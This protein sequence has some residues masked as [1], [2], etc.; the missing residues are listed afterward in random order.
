VLERNRTLAAHLARR[1]ESLRGHPHV[2]NLRRTG[3]IAAFDLVKDKASR[4]PY[5]GAERRGLRFY[6]HALS[7]GVLLRP[8]GDTVYFLPPYC[9]DEHDIDAMVAVATEAVDAATG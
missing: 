8:L 3:W 6:R 7:R 2:A 4:A 1:L 9:I 5:P